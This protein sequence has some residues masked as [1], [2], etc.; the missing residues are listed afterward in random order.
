MDCSQYKCIF[1]EYFIFIFNII[2]LEQLSR[3]GS[4]SLTNIPEEV[5]EHVKLLLNVT[6]TV[7]PDAD[8]MTK[9]SMY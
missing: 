7:R 3:L 8:Q 9:V 6:P 4:S 2:T 5:R 1:F